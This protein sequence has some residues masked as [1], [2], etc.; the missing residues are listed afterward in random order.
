[1]HTLSDLLSF[2]LQQDRSIV[3]GN[4]GRYPQLLFQTLVALPQLRVIVLSHHYPYASTDP[5]IRV[6]KPTEPVDRCDLLVYVEPASLQWVAK[7]PLASRVAVFT[8]HYTFKWPETE[9]WIHVSFFHGADPVGTAQLLARQQF[10]IHTQNIGLVE[11]DHANTV[12]LSGKHPAAP[13]QNGAFVI[14]DLTQFNADTLSMYLAFWD[15]F[16]YMLQHRASVGDWV[17]CFSAKGHRAFKRFAQ[18]VID[19]LFCRKFEYGNV[20]DYRDLLA[21]LPFYQS[22]SIDATFPLKK[23]SFGGMVFVAPK[24]VEE[25]CR[26]AVMQDVWPVAKNVLWIPY[27]ENQDE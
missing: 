18:K 27:D 7:Q 24:T 9:R 22:G 10:P 15:A 25:A 16:D 3:F 19:A 20:T 17:T 12:T 14:V 23:A 2:L 4:V 1:M 6:Q 26:A 5:R 8:S 21:L 11:V 13:P